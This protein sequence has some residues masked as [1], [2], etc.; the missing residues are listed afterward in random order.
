[1]EE[2]DRVFASGMIVYVDA[3]TGEFAN[4]EFG[5]RG[6]CMR[7]VCARLIFPSDVMT[8]FNDIPHSLTK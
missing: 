7:C 1:M 5:E 4:G 3:N 8:R 2:R 6:D